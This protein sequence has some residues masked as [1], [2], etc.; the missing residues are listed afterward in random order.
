VLTAAAGKP[1]AAGATGPAGAA[2]ATGPAGATGAQGPQGAT[3]EKGDT[4]PATGAASGDLTGNYP[5]PTIAAGA[6]TPAKTGARPA[7]V[8]TMSTDQSL[9]SNTSG[10][11]LAVNTEQFD[12][13]GLHAGSDHFLTAPIDGVYAIAASVCWST[14][15][16]GLR[17][18]QLQVAHDVGSGTSF[19]YAVSSVAPVNGSQTCQTA[20]GLRSMVAGDRVTALPY[21]SSGTT[22]TI[23]SDPYVYGANLS[24]VW[25]GP[26]G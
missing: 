11:S 2:G 23:S 12:V 16:S 4:G 19:R 22:L 6:I 18:V 3:G 9:N 20:Q 10:T 26:T 1:G 25:M 7:A 8:L 13:G 17:F 21:Q 5:A 14:N 15:A 24:M